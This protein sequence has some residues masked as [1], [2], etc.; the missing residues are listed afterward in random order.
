MH[1][2]IHEVGRNLQHSERSLLAGVFFNVLLPSWLQT[3][4]L[5][6]L[7]LIVIKKTLGKGV[8]MWQSERKDADLKAKL[9]E[10]QHY[11]DV[12]TESDNEGVMH[13]EAYHLKPHR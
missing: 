11:Q 10:D 1:S 4:L 7:L 6:I 5:T 12:D 3:V 9:L 13:E 2:D 8:R